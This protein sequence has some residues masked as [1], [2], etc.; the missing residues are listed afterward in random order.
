MNAGGELWPEVATGGELE[1]AQDEWLHTNGTG[2]Y[3]MSTVALM[4]T[5]R[6]HGILV[7]ALDPPFG[8]YVVL[9]HA[10][11]TLHVGD[12]SHRLATHQFPDVAPTPGYRLLQRFRQDPIPRWDYRVGKGEFERA[13]CLAR[14]KN[15]LILRY[16][17]RGKSKG[18][19]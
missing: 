12:R 19:G 1:R 8:R 3:A 6:Y 5:R 2:A 9:S 18:E 10:E 7:A 17:W 15:V 4:H 14:D 11:L 13:L 16:C